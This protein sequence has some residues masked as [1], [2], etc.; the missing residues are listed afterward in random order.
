MGE[1]V[2]E[3]R[4]KGNDVFKIE[5]KRDEGRGGGGR[6]G[7][8]EKKRSEVFFVFKKKR[9]NVMSENDENG[10]KCVAM[11]ERSK[12]NKKKRGRDGAQLFA[13]CASVARHLGLGRGE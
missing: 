1:G 7:G 4:G 12:I 2:G 10:K 6:G 13:L 11:G 5:N 8:R 3:K 9:R